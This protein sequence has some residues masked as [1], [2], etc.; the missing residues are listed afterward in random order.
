[1]NS[2][3]LVITCL[4]N[5]V[6]FILLEGILIFAIIYPVFKEQLMLG[7]VQGCAALNATVNAT[8]SE[9]KIDYTNIRIQR[10]GS[11]SGGFVKVSHLF[12]PYE[13]GSLFVRLF[14][15]GLL[16]RPI[17]EEY[18]LI[19]RNTVIATLIYIIL[20]LSVPLC[21][22]IIYLINRI[23]LGDAKLD[24]RYMLY[25]IGLTWLVSG[26]FLALLGLLVVS[27]LADTLEISDLAIKI[28][29]YI[30]QKLIVLIQEDGGD[31]NA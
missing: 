14:I 22:I 5:V 18:T 12:D 27:Y 13:M 2:Y 15:I 3:S 30:K 16:K 20:A 10:V 25:D 31:P 7:M 28:L 11:N 24:I 1:M 29:L 9:Y 21:I 26:V 23:F 17:V 4:M 19:K 6:V 8:Y